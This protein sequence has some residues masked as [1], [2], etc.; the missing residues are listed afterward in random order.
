MGLLKW[1]LRLHDDDL[2]QRDRKRGLKSRDYGRIVPE[3]FEITLHNGRKIRF[4][5]E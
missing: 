1:L 2:D 3:R 4:G 5:D